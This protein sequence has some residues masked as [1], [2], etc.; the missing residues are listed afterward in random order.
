MSALVAI[1]G[2]Q[3]GQVNFADRGQ[4]RSA[5]RAEGNFDHAARFITFAIPD[6]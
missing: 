3:S 1:I 4:R 6:E 5:P 2:R